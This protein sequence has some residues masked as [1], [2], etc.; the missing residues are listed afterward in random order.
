MS[1]LT[2]WASLFC[3][4]DQRTVPRLNARGIEAPHCFLV[5]MLLSPSSSLLLVQAGSFLSRMTARAA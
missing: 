1:G 5:G 4:F 3:D 2:A